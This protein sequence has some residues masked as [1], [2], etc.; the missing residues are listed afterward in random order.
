[1][2][3]VFWRLGHLNRDQAVRPLGPFIV[4]QRDRV[5][6]TDAQGWD[7]GVRP[8]MPLHELKWRYPQAMLVPWN[9]EHYRENHRQLRLWL[10]AHMASYMQED[11]REGWWEWPQI[12]PNKV[13]ALMAE[14]IPR[15]ALRAEM[16]IA[17]HPI[18]AKWVCDQGAD[19]GLKSW[20]VEDAQVF[21]MFPRQEEKFWP[22]L[23][24]RY[25]AD[26]WP[27]RRQ[28][29]KLRGWHVVGEVPG[30]V[31]EVRTLPWTW[32]KR[33]VSVRVEQVLEGGMNQ[34]IGEVMAQ[35]AHRLVDYLRQKNQ[36]M[37]H[38]RLIWETERGTEQ[39]ERQWP[40]MVAERERV[41]SRVL[42]LM[43]NLPSAIPE[44]LILEVDDPEFVKSEQLTL[45]GGGQ[46]SRM[47]LG[48]HSPAFDIG[49]RENL[50]Q[51]WDIWRM[52]SSLNS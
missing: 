8:H 18:L 20:A 6:D 35:V 21:V 12:E 45:W 44:K 4:F 51:F 32:Q 30:L 16:G 39:R 37:A 29:W 50:L 40:E 41:V 10:E 34:G 1:M 2:G 19:M 28:E 27:K 5:F 26:Q 23:P 48:W 46:K 33:P 36:G 31:H 38:L 42:S 9:P 47:K 14:I 52:P 3:V 11:C 43:Q 17:S 15:W 7:L 13:R 24:L 49:R 22:H 25:I